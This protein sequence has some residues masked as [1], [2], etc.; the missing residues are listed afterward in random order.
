MLQQGEEILPPQEVSFEP[1]R[2][3]TYASQYGS[4]VRAATRTDDTCGGMKK[5]ELF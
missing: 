2:S 3:E 5:G 1:R 4:E